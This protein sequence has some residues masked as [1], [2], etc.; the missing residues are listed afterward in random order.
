MI[1]NN[2]LKN[3][4]LRLILSNIL[5]FGFFYVWMLRENIGQSGGGYDMSLR[6]LIPCSC[7]YQIFYGYI[8]YNK[9]RNIMLPN[10]ILY[11]FILFILNFFV[12][13]YNKDLNY[14]SI[15]I[16]TLFA[17]FIFNLISVFSSIIGKIVFKIKE[18]KNKNE[19]E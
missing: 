6:V 10:I 7:V 16:P 14:I 4:Y 17:S 11:L 9:T 18:K 12:L 13:R 3:P 1:K 19:N 2:V 5:F 15:M 8:S